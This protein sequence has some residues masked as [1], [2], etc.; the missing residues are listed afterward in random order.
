MKKNGAMPLLLLPRMLLLRADPQ[1]FP[2]SPRLMALA[3]AAHAATDVLSVLDQMTP[4]RAVMAGV[5]DTLLL[6]AFAQVVLRLRSLENRLSQTLTALA[7]CGALLSLIGWAVGNAFAGPI[8]LEA[9]WVLSLLWYFAVS[10][11]ILRHALDR[12]FIVGV[13]L[14]VLYFVLASTMI[15][16]VIGTPTATG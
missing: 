7:G 12:S 13:A 3:L 1:D 2:T 11:H 5:L 4:G 15:A 14:S 16:I 9:I 10:G 6:A 8:P